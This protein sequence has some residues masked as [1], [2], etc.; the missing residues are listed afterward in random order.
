M[1]WCFLWWVHL[2]AACVKPCGTYRSLNMM[3]VTLHGSIRCCIEKHV[4]HILIHVWLRTEV[5]SS[6]NSSDWGSNSWPPDHDSTFHVTKT[7]AL[8][9]WPFIA[10]YSVLQPQ[11]WWRDAMHT[12][13]VLDQVWHGGLLHREQ[14]AGVDGNMLLRLNVTELIGGKELLRW[15]SI[16]DWGTICAGVPQGSILYP[17]FFFLYMQHVPCSTFVKVL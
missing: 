12:P 4:L 10:V 11:A 6:P 8:T 1:T 14:K 2:L 13:A 17:L 9:T 7:P 3:N 5:P 16:S 15:P